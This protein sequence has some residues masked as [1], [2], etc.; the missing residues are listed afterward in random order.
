M[1]SQQMLA[2]M[3]NES[4]Q[5]SDERHEIEAD[6]RRAVRPR[7][8][9]LV[10]HATAIHGRRSGEGDRACR[11][12]SSSTGPPAAFEWAFSPEGRRELDRARSSAS[13]GA[14]RGRLIAGALIANGL[15]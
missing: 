14:R 4:C 3:R 2:G 10:D 8:A 7:M 5:A 9:E 11:P 15:A 6:V 12:A 13:R 1:A